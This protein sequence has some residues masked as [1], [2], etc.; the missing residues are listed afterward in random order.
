M[1]VTRSV[2][3]SD[4]HPTSKEAVI[5]LKNV[6]WP[7]ESNYRTLNLEMGIE[8]NPNRTNRTRT[9]I[10]EEPNRT[11]THQTKKSRTRTE[12]M[13]RK[14]PNRTRTLRSGF[15]S[16]FGFTVTV[17]KNSYLLNVNSFYTPV[18]CITILCFIVF[19]FMP[20]V[21]DYYKLQFSSC[22]MI[23]ILIS[24]S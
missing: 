17:N 4:G 20:T 18:E 15:L 3:A 23:F 10:L 2:T 22:V 19:N 11:R 14:N 5:L 16:V 24:K 21:K 1:P 13:N 6:S 12:P 8:P 7:N 9:L